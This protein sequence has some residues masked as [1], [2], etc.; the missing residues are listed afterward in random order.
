V[1]LDMSVSNA[2]LAA[3]KDPHLL[4][5]MQCGRMQPIVASR[6][7][8]LQRAKAWPQGHPDEQLLVNWLVDVQQG[9]NLAASAP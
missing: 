7:P 5:R 4:S 9:E 1:L 8:R 3:T 6:I 2:H